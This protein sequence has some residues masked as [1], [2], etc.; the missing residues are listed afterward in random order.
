MAVTVGINLMIPFIHRGKETF[1]TNTSLIDDPH[2]RD[3]IK[4]EWSEW[5]NHIRR[6]S[7]IVHWW[8]NHV[9]R[10]VKYLFVREGTERISYRNRIG[11]FIMRPF[12]ISYKNPSH[13]PTKITTLK[14]LRAQ[15]VRLNS[16]FHQRTMPDTEEHD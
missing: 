3:H 1:Y 14:N 13:I 4:M 9:K 16:T 7:S 15:I 8:E 10:K 12:T 5:K 2:C 11:N 6:Y